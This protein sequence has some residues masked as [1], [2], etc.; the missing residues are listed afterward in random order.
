MKSIKPYT[1]L[2][3]VVTMLSCSSDND[4][5]GNNLANYTPKLRCNTNTVVGPTAAYWDYG[6]S[7]PPPLTQVPILKNTNGQFIHS[8]HPYLGFPV[9]QG[10]QAFEAQDQQTSPLGV[11]VIRNDNAA[12]WRYVPLAT[13]PLNFSVDNIIGREINQM[14]GFYGFSG[15]NFEVLCENKPAPVIEGGIARIFSSRLIRFG[16]FTGLVW[17]NVVAVQGLPTLSVSASVSAGPTNQYDNLVMETFLPL[18]FQ[19]LVSDRESLSDRDND[20]TPDVFDSQPD[21]PN[22]Q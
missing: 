7:I 8:Q 6:N 17:V 20:G 12:I 21:N 16:D 15:N 3:I 10:Y 22:V 9:P 14:F 19:L 2:L 11:N 18:S 5:N 1:L 4:G 13:Y